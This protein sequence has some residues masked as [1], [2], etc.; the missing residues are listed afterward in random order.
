VKKRTKQCATLSSIALAL[1]T[2]VPVPALAASSQTSTK[3][4]GNSSASDPSNGNGADSSTTGGGGGQSQGSK[5]TLGS[6]VGQI[7]GA[8]LS[9]DEIKVCSVKIAESLKA[10]LL[11]IKASSA[12][13]ESPSLYLYDQAQQQALAPLGVFRVQALAAQDR[14]TK[15]LNQPRP[16]PLGDTAKQVE[17]NWIG[18]IPAAAAALQSVLSLFTT[19]VGIGGIT[20]SLDD[21]PL[22]AEVGG[23]LVSTVQDLKFYRP[24]L[25]FPAAFDDSAIGG[26]DTLEKLQALTSKRDEAAGLIAQ[27]QAEEGTLT[28]TLK[29]LAASKLAPKDLAEK[30]SDLNNAVTDRIKYVAELQSAVSAVDAVLLPL[31]GGP[32]ASSSPADKKAADGTTSPPKTG[33]G[34]Q[35]TTTTTTVATS[36]T[37]TITPSSSSP[38][39]AT[40]PAPTKSSA[41]PAPTSPKESTESALG[42]LLVADA[43]A[44]RILKKNA[45]LLTLHLPEAGGSY[46]TRANFWTFFGS[47][48]IHYS[49]GVVATYSAVD[50]PTGAILDS[51]TCTAYIGHVAPSEIGH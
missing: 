45:V 32:D 12:A 21:E 44:A 5:V 51:G 16:K 37:T 42:N 26:S 11:R 40:G 39:S 3:G 27:Y 18:T 25:Y 47:S 1:L 33:A 19:S 35:S 6:N 28:T 14:I 15:A 17:F 30:R 24:S 4:A 38:A 9:D 34:G 13:G 49:G 41:D 46:E 10:V 22:N 43:L 2:Q 7:E 50:G 23:Q 20:V 48:P 29:S 31:I 36:T 8:V